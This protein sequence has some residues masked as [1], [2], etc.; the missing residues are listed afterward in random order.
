MEEIGEKSEYDTALAVLREGRYQEAG[1]A[2]RKFLADHPRS[3]YADNAGYWLGEA[4]YVTREFDRAQ[5]AFQSVVDKYPQSAKV[6][7]SRLK[8]AYI[9]YEIGISAIALSSFDE[10]IAAL[11]RTAEGGGVFC[12][13][14]FKATGVRE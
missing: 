8:L 12:Y 5:G 6:P 13:T 2:F 7:G 14:F 3:I 1:E 10:G 9:Y 4:Y 11:R